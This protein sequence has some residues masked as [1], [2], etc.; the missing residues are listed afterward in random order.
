MQVNCNA[1]GNGVVLAN[2]TGN[3]ATS[4]SSSVHLRFEEI[5]V[6]GNQTA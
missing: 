6:P 3:V 4:V 2:A 1:T 5:P